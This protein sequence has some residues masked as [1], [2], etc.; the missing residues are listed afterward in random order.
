[1][2][3]LGSAVRVERRQELRGE[4]EQL[5]ALGVRRADVEHLHF[6]LTFL[7]RAEI[8]GLESGVQA[9]TGSS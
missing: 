5:L 4:E 8:C 3:T 9:G 6:F 7:G 1:M 2:Y